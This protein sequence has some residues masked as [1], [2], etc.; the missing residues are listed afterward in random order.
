VLYQTWLTAG[1]AGLGRYELKGISR[2]DDVRWRALVLLRELGNL[3]GSRPQ[4]PREAVM[5][6]QNVLDKCFR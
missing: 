2:L 1:Q 5:W 6:D 4:D 3:I